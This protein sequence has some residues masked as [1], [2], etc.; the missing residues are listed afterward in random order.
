MNIK[1]VIGTLIAL[2]IFALLVA[3]F[4]P[5]IVNRFNNPTKPVDNTELYK[6]F[7]KSQDSLASINIILLQAHY[8][9]SLS[10]DSI[11]KRAAQNE[12]KSVYLTDKK[13]ERFKLLNNATL[14]KQDSFMS[15]IHITT[16]N[17]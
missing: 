4:I 16:D 8:K 1:A 10:T 15:T 14:T 2:L 3:F 17:H 12:I 11:K 5:I 13:H 9:D 6:R 7:Q